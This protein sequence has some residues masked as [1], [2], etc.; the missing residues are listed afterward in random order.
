MKR[1]AIAIPVAALLLGAAACSDDGGNAEDPVDTAAQEETSADESTTPVELD[2]EEAGGAC[3]LIDGDLLDSVTGEHFRFASGGPEP[4]GEEEDAP[5]QLSCAVQTGEA[6]YP[7][8]TTFIAPT[9]ASADV[10]KDEEP[11][12]SEEIEDLGDAAYWIVHTE[13][14]G[15]GPALELGWL[16]DGNMFEMRY[17]TPEGTEAGTVEEL[18]PGFTDLAKSINQANADAAE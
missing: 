3:T 10:Y 8:L 15:A 13:D 17:T 12:D 9:D 4:D 18:V 16:A 1:L 11:G 5:A 6:A 2:L 7:D 14:T